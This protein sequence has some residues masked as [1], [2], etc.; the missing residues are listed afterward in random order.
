[1]SETEPS[2]ESSPPE[3]TPFDTHPTSASTS[4]SDLDVNVDLEPKDGYFPYNEE[5]TLQ[6]V[7]LSDSSSLRL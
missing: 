2:R 6:H 1:M 3:A 7:R 5:K 4:L